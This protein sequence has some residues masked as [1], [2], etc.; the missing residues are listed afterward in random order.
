MGMQIQ[1]RVC[2]PIVIQR[3]RYQRNDEFLKS[4][5]S[6]HEI[7]LQKK[8]AHK[9]TVELVKKITHK[10]AKKFFKIENQIKTFHF[11]LQRRSEWQ[12]RVT[13]I[14]CDTKNERKIIVIQSLMRFQQAKKKIWHLRQNGVLWLFLDAKA[15]PEDVPA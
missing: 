10:N 15:W 11:C 4:K 13:H 14:K 9:A 6:I 1:Y 2:I 3:R 8:I 5:K 12:K 7:E